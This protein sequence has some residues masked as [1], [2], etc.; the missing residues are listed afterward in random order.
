MV[1]LNSVRSISLFQRAENTGEGDAGNE[2]WYV[3]NERSKPKVFLV[4][5][6]HNV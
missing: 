5:G 4:S 2:K 3:E 6:H 1:L